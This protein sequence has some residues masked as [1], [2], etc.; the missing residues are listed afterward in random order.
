[1]SLGPYS[2]PSGGLDL[3]RQAVNAYTSGDYDAAALVCRTAVEESLFE[4]LT[5]RWIPE[6]GWG[7]VAPENLPKDLGTTTL[8]DLRLAIS[9]RKT[10]T[11]QEEESIGRI[12]DDGNTIAHAAKR[13]REG[14]KYV[15]SKFSTGQQPTKGELRGPDLWVSQREVLD[16]LRSTA[17]V[18]RRVFDAAR[19]D[20]TGSPD[21]DC[22]PG[23]G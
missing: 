9:Y 5:R 3:F 8:Q 11:A 21:S 16:D 17:A 15:R 2:L 19:V 13:L 6:T 7:I 20:A 18:L 4:F 23:P 22:N 14:T 12:Q 10:L 1:M